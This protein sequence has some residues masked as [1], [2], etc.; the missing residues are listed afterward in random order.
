MFEPGQRVHISV[1]VELTQGAFHTVNVL[2]APTLPERV[3][4]EQDRERFI[5]QNCQGGVWSNTLWTTE[6]DRKENRYTAAYFFQDQKD[7]LFFKLFHG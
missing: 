6:K 2:T 7:A 4:A 5:K 1:L 3:A